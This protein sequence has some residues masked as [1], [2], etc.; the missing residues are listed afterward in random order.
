[1]VTKWCCHAAT[2]HLF[3][4]IA[5]VHCEKEKKQ[6]CQP[7]PETCTDLRDNDCDGLADCADSDC[8]S[9]SVCSTCHPSGTYS[10]DYNEIGDCGIVGN[11]TFSGVSISTSDDTITVSVPEFGDYVGVLDEVS[12]EALFTEEIN[13]PETEEYYSYEGTGVITLTF[14]A[15]GFSGNESGDLGPDGVRRGSGHMLAE[16]IDDGDEN[17]SKVIANVPT[18]LLQFLRQIVWDGGRARSCI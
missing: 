5:T 15:S 6:G 8:S 1:M 4:V 11:L 13:I 14:T 2:F 7:Q 12:C 17:L 16:R 18:R 10:I 3:I 9:Q